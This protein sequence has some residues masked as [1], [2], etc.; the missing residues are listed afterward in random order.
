VTDQR[1]L[2]AG[3]THKGPTPPGAPRFDWH[4]WAMLGIHVA[5]LAVEGDG[6]RINADQRRQVR[7][8]LRPAPDYRHRTE[9]EL[10]RWLGAT[11][12]DGRTARLGKLRRGLFVGGLAVLVVHL[13]TDGGY[14]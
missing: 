13:V 5:W 10:G 6:F 14:L 12:R 11:D 3:L 7:E 1:I 8:G 9:T 2:T 4:A